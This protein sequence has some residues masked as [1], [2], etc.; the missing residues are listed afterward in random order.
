MAAN[1]LKIVVNGEMDPVKQINHEGYIEVVEQLIFDVGNTGN[2]DDFADDGGGFSRT[3]T[4]LLLKYA[5]SKGGV[6]RQLN[7]G[8]A[9]EDVDRKNCRIRADADIRRQNG[10]SRITISVPENK[11]TDGDLTY[12]D[13]F[14]NKFLDIYKTG[15]TLPTPTSDTTAK[16]ARKFAFGMMMLTKCR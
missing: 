9:P 2:F 1:S 5:N 14:I 12:I 3:R 13:D 4:S 8:G 11:L 7:A 15:T 10:S 6:L 16:N